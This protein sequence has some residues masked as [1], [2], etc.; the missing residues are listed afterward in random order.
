MLLAATVLLLEGEEIP[1]PEHVRGWFYRV[2]SGFAPALHDA[3]ELKPFTLGILRRKQT[4]IRITFLEEP[5]HAASSPSLWSLVGKDLRLGSNLFRVRAVVE[6]GHPWARLSSYRR[7]FHGEPVRDYPLH[8][9]SPTLFKRHGMH[10]PLPEPRLVFGSLLA[11]FEA[12][13][14]V[15]PP[16][17][18][19]DSI[20]RLTL[21]AVRIHTHPIQH[22]VRAVGFTGRVVYHLPGASQEEAR[23]LTALWRFAFFSGVGAK[24][25]LGFGM[26]KPYAPLTVNAKDRVPEPDEKPKV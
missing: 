2:L 10:Y 9:A 16:S 13:S 5:L 25:T 26:S 7:L 6:D 1:S 12:F 8:F 21:R 15:T 23:W 4:A 3:H 19:Q 14:P 20:E 18:L 24:T 22:A 11:R 17:D